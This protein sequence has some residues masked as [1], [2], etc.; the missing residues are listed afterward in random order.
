MKAD[1]F[2][3]PIER[4]MT[5]DHARLEALL[6]SADGDEPGAYDAFRRGLLRHI[7]IEAKALLPYVRERRFGDPWPVEAQLRSD[8]AL[9]TKLIASAPTPQTFDRLR[10]VLALHTALEEGPSGLYAACDGLAGRDVGLV[11]DLVSTF[12]ENALPSAIETG[13]VST[14]LSS[15]T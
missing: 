3:G 5:E 12:Q 1:S 7:A 4:L 15:T 13:S 14:S 9:L 8:H 2:A 11:L 10:K 6:G